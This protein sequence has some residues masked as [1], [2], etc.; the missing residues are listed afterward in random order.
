MGPVSSTLGGQKPRCRATYLG[1]MKVDVV[2]KETRVHHDHGNLWPFE[3][4]LCDIMNLVK[5]KVLLW[6]LQS[7][8]SS[9]PYSL[10]DGL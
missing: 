2:V 9:G 6:S 10:C 1:I 5:N 4:V 3:S 8:E 7:A